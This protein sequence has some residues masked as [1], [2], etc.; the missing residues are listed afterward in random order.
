MNVLYLLL[1]LA[2]MLGLLGLILMIWAVK[3]GQFEDLEG[4]AQRILFEDD[5]ALMPTPGEEKKGEPS[6]SLA[7]GMRQT[8]QTERPSDSSVEGLS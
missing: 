8:A 4:P 2:L 3:T 1:P 5:Q 6:S 7:P